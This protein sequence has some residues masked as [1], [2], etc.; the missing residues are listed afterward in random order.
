MPY[1]VVHVQNLDASRLRILGTSTTGDPLEF[2]ALSQNNALGNSDEWINSDTRLAK[3][4]GC[5]LDGGENPSGGC[6]SFV[7]WADSGD[8]VD[9]VF[10]NEGG[11]MGDGWEWSLSIPATQLNVKKSSSAE[12]AGP[13]DTVEYTVIATNVGDRDYTSENPAV[14]LDDLSGVLDD[15]TYN[16]DAAA[17]QTGTVAFDSRVLS[18][19]GALPAGETVTLTYT[20]TLKAGGDGVARN[21]AWEPDPG[22][23]TPPVCDPPDEN[24]LDPDTG[25]PCAFTET[26]LPRLSVQKT[27]D[28]TELPVVGGTVTYTVTVKN[29]GPGDYSDDAPATF[30]DD[31]ADVLDAATYNKDAAASTGAVSYAEPKLSWSG[32]L[33]AGESATITYTATYTGGGDQNLRNVAC[34]PEDEVA[35]GQE[36]CDFV[37]IPGAALTQWKKVSSS[38]SPA[39]AGSVLTYTLFFKNTGGAAADVDAIDDLT[40]VLDDA[41]ITTEPISPDGLAVTRDGSRISV[42]GQVPSGETYQVT[43]TATIKAD[44]QRGDNISSNFLMKNRPDDP[45][46]PPRVPTCK[47]TDAQLPDCT[48]TPIAQVEYAKSVSA[49]SDPVE[50]G[51]VL[52]YTV[53]VKSTGADTTAVSREDVLAGVLD[54]ATLTGAPR[55]DTETVT[56]S[57]GAGGRIRIGGELAAGRTATITY[58]VTVRDESDRGDN[59]AD[60]FIVPPGEEPPSTC[61]AGDTT[62]TSTPLPKIDVT[63]SVT[64]DDGSAVQEGQEVTY[65]LTFANTGAAAGTIDHTDDLAGVLDD[66]TLTT[67]ASSS[68]PALVATSGEDGKVRV[69]GTLDVGQTV[70]VKY[71]VT[72]RADGDRGDNRLGNVVART[73]NPHPKCGDD[74]VSCTE[75]PI[76]ELDDWKTVDPA[77]GT[78]VRP[79][80]VLTYTLHFENTGTA[81]KAFSRDDVLTDMVDDADVTSQPSSSSDALSVSGIADGRF[82]V[83][84][85]LQA[86]ESAT[87]TY[88][89]TVRA[90][91][92][93][94]DDRLGNFLIG[95][96]ETPDGE[97]RPEDADH[98]DCTVNH[99]SDMRVTKS[100]DPASGEEVNP[101]QKVT[102]TLTFVNTSANPDSAPAEVDY[103][104]H[105]DDV[106]DDADLVAGPDASEGGLA[107]A[108]DGGTIRITGSVASGQTATV[109]YTVKV[110]SYDKQGDHSLGNVVAATGEDPVCA[111]G[112]SL[113]TRHDVPEPKPGNP[114][115]STG[116]EGTALLLGSVFVL[117]AGG[118]AATAVRRRRDPSD[119]EEATSPLK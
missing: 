37:Q 103:T 71:T 85:T 82:T 46:E 97:C 9:L 55:S 59:R 79:G 30:E 119:R 32:A 16:G 17:D 70:T 80:D 39:V 2:R 67:A 26:K 73:D 96:G 83:N 42:T 76:G 15:A 19:T 109:T 52:T 22:D 81:P 64:P 8:V 65:T 116:A 36:R 50:A 6:G 24:G 63:K 84:G 7:V 102:Y 12:S 40:H 10:E 44:G 112:S 11:W 34:I 47:P 49:S 107:A 51:T 106:L 18:W 90:E 115:A 21:V 86:G 45:P 60:N 92:Q 43:Y 88:Q 93:R 100:S 89:A 98:S 72:V 61:P 77:I 53:T 110:R 4:I 29:V 38:D 69:T 20:V 87:V 95:P 75:N 104:D 56:V 105:M 13:G 113:C 66:A 68:D 33:A 114:L 99:V 27:A 101:G 78:T 14:L 91:G 108:A 5:Q 57:D 31:L 58:Q 54:D 3:N 118:M 35:P 117:M 48:E 23:P 94:G 74:G 28:R 62:C 41:D 1:V 111:T 25:Q